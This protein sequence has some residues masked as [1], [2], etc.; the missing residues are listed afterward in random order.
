L[1]PLRTEWWKFAASIGENNPNWVVFPGKMSGE[2]L[3]VAALSQQLRASEQ[4]GSPAL[5]KK[6]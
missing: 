1:A 3:V 5:P 2:A 6:F 4:T